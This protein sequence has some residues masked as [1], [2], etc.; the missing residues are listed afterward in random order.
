MT[1][2]KA[3]LA[4]AFLLAFAAGTS[5]GLFA[6]RP[7]VSQ[8]LPRP[9]GPRGGPESFL[10]RELNLSKDQQEQMRKIWS[11]VMGPG[12]RG[13]FDRRSALAQD[14]DQAVLALLTEE[15]RVK[16]DAILQ[17]HA[18]K[19]EAL[20]Q[21][22]KRAFENAVE[23]TKEILTPEQA[24][25]YEELMKKQRDRGP[26]GPP[27]FSGPG[28]PPGRGPRHRHTAPTSGPASMESNTPR[29]GE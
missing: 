10:A 25:K 26:G 27:G 3:I 29:V 22:R 28:G 17:D 11:E 23:R 18:A 6:S 5:V 19:L 4:A 1:R 13:P 16:Y 24:A 2:T 8:P 14:R 7:A 12:G 21:E 9:A 15:Q 20:S